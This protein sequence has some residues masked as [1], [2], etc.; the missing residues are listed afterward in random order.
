M[1]KRKFGFKGGDSDDGFEDSDD[2]FFGGDTEDGSCFWG[3]VD[4]IDDHLDDEGELEEGWLLNKSK[5]GDTNL[6]VRIGKGSDIVCSVTCTA[7]REKK[8]LGSLAAWLVRRGANVAKAR[9]H[10]AGDTTSELNEVS[11]FFDQDGVPRP[12]LSAKVSRAAH[13]NGWL[14][15]EEVRVDEAERGHDL[16]LHMIN[17]VL[18]HLS[19]IVSLATL[20]PFSLNRRDESLDETARASAFNAANTKLARHF[21]RLSFAQLANTTPESKVWFLEVGRG[22]V[23]VAARGTTDQLSVHQAAPKPTRTG[24]NLKL[25][26]L[27]GTE[28][29]TSAALTKLVKEEGAN[30]DVATAMHRAATTRRVDLLKL[31]R[32]LGGNVNHRDV[33]GNTPLHVACS[34]GEEGVAVACELERLGADIDV[35]NNRGQTPADA[36][37]EAKQNMSDFMRAFDLGC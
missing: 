35:R 8:K 32:N 33:L 16:S 9:F 3:M 6:E 15:V 21:A 34:L 31:L 10:E 17:A 13:K 30:V 1:R 11:M 28:T 14:H 4:G 22:A 36:R 26:E 25:F 29:P 24:A 27:L 7:T 20:C 12:H 23:P 37:A 18:S 2:D 5:L 19:V